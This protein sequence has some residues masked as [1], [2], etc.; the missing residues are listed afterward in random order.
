MRKSMYPGVL[1]PQPVRLQGD[2]GDLKVS[3]LPYYHH[4]VK[5]GKKDHATLQ[6]VPA[7]N[8]HPHVGTY[9]LS[10]SVVACGSAQRC[11]ASRTK[12]WL[13]QRHPLSG[14]TNEMASWTVRWQ[15]EKAPSLVACCGTASDS[16]RSFHRSLVLEVYDARVVPKHDHLQPVPATKRSKLAY[17]GL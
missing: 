1:T 15:P 11:A 2:V 14:L 12:A 10:A 16:D 13:V 6:G 4:H 5:S 3:G 8:R 17:Q 9:E 7:A